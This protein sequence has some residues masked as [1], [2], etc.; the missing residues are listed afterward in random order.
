MQSSRV[1]GFENRCKPRR[2]VLTQIRRKNHEPLDLL[3][4]SK[5]IHRIGFD[6]GQ[7]WGDLLGSGYAQRPGRVNPLGFDDRPVGLLGDP[8]DHGRHGREFTYHGQLCNFLHTGVFG[9]TTGDQSV[10]Q[11]RFAGLASRSIGC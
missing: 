2:I 11:D 6:F 3:G 5:I 4:L 10:E 9:S 1:G 7:F 8:A